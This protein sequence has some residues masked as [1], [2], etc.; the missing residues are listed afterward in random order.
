M[1]TYHDGE[2]ELLT[3]LD[4]LK[5]IVLFY[6]FEEV[7]NKKL[8]IR[9]IP[10][11]TKYIPVGQESVYEKIGES[12]YIL[13]IGNTKDRM[14]VARTINKMMGGELKICME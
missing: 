4:A 3:T 9:G 8:L 6:G 13:N 5:K 7:R 12:M 1:I 14:N 11:L 2:V 10:L